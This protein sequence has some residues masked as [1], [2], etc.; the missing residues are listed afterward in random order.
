MRYE[1]KPD[2]PKQR[3]GGSGDSYAARPYH[4]AGRSVV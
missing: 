4:M 2:H 3:P 1:P